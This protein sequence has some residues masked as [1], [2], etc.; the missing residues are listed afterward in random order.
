MERTS[1]ENADVVWTPSNVLASWLSEQGWNLSRGVH[2]L[3]L[4]PG[5]EVRG[6]HESVHVKAK[7]LVFFGRLEKRK[8]LMLFCDS[9]DLLASM[10]S[11]KSELAITF[12]GTTGFVNGE[13]SV[14]YI[15]GRSAKWPFKTTIISNATRVSALEYLMERRAGRIPVCVPT[16]SP[17]FRCS[18]YF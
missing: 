10:D 16:P 6:V 13:D 3:P 12:L 18:Y 8:G 9:V 11:V 2:L 7:E 14:A 1:V 15:K 4:P 17:P 5:P